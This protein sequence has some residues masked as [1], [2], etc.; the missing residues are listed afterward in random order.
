MSGFKY[1]K[2][3][4][5][6]DANLEEVIDS[7]CAE[8]EASGQDKNTGSLD[9][10][11]SAIDRLAGVT[12]REEVKAIGETPEAKQGLKEYMARLKLR[13][14]NKRDSSLVDNFL[15]QAKDKE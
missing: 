4:Q 12:T 15:K 14:L 11:P 1:T 3:A 8:K 2:T 7:H 9:T 6:F 10:K 5:E 13:D